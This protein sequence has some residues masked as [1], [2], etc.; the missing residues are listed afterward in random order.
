MSSTSTKCHQDIKTDKDPFFSALKF[1]VNN[2]T[3]LS[4]KW[5][6]QL[7]CN[8]RHWMLLFSIIF[9]SICWY[10]FFIKNIHL[11]SQN[12]P[13]STFAHVE[14]ILQTRNTHFS[15]NCECHLAPHFHALKMDHCT[16][17]YRGGTWW[18][19]RQILQ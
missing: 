19:T 13:S 1:G 11:P 17:F 3:L 18:C 8:E 7:I 4:A 12:I 9:S 16:W 14:Q 10:S 2:D 15:N 5:Y 6:V